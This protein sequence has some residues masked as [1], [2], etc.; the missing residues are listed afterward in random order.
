MTPAQEKKF[1]KLVERAKRK[2]RKAQDAQAEASQAW[3]QDARAEASQAWVQASDYLIACGTD[4]AMSNVSKH[5]ISH[6]TGSA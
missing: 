6:G 5:Q 1:H 4:E 2:S 3:V